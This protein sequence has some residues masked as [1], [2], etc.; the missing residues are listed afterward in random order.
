M[1]VDEVSDCGD[2]NNKS[3]GNKEEGT[4]EVQPVA[5]SIGP[6]MS[7]TGLDVSSST[8]RTERIHRPPIKCSDNVLQ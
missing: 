8:I 6:G 1:I 2:N 4:E 5:V 3:E 7:T